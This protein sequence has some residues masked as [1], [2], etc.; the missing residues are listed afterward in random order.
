M[1]CCGAAHVLAATMLWL[2]GFSA[3]A[4]EPPLWGY[5]DA[6]GVAHFS[7]K[8]EDSRYT[9]VLRQGA[10]DA[11]RVPGK[12]ASRQSLLT[13]LAFAPEVKALLP[14]LREAEAA[15][16]VDVE[17]LQ[18]VIA[19][20]SGFKPDLVSPKGAMGLMQIT[21]DTGERYATKAER[22]ARPV[23]ERLRDPRS[24]IMT[25]ARMLADLSRRMGGIAP[26]LAAW[27]AGEGNVRRHGGKVPPFAETQAHV[28]LVLEVY[29]ELLQ[30]RQQRKVRTM[31]LVSTS[32]TPG[33]TL[34]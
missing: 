8:Q 10:K 30:Q 4:A 29:W 12:L 34:R 2:L 26:A 6:Q 17:L 19:V 25:G 14:L 20:E 23:E 24:N 13:W 28:H 5:V 16:G 31:N 33:A 9:P 11:G 32:I 15:T 27:N 3:C 22:A 21:P 18:A 1:R 7:A